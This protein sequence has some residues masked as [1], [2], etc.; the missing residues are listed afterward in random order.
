MNIHDLHD[1]FKTGQDKSMAYFFEGKEIINITPAMGKYFLTFKNY[2]STKIENHLMYGDEKITET[3][4]E[5][6]TRYKKI[7]A[8]ITEEERTPQTEHGRKI[9]KL[10]REKTNPTPEEEKRI[11]S[12]TAS[13]LHMDK[14]QELEAIAEAIQIINSER[15]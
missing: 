5:Y 8:G 7:V 4:K 15:R 10:Y 3:C 13:I 12:I 2:E 1:K 6:A 11:F 9:M 14:G